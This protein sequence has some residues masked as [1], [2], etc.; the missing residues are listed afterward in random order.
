[1]SRITKL[2][3]KDWDSEL[4][5]MFQA[6]SATTL[7]LGTMRIFAHCPDI[8]KGIIALGAGIRADRTL[9]ERLI[10][11]VRLRVAFHNQCRSCMAIRYRSAVEAGVDEGLVCS[12]ENPPEAEDLTEAEKTAIAYADKF[13]T[14]HLSINDGDFIELRRHFSEAQ[15]VELGSWVAFCVGFGRLGAVWDMVEELPEAYQERSGKPVAPWSGE[16]EIVR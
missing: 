9:P 7:E 4:R 1:M 5:E 6:D 3:P 12:L 16:P 15:L 2:D 14:D 8:A 11:L 13:A 10:E